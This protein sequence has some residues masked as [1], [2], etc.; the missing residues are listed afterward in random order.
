MGSACEY[1]KLDNEGENGIEEDDEKQGETGHA[2]QE[3]GQVYIVILFILEW[4]QPS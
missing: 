3:E 2:T 4:S 1:K